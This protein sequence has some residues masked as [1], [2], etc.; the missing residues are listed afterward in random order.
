[1]GFSEKTP[2]QV[3]ENIQIE[4]ETMTSLV[5]G[6][7][8]QCGKLTTPSLANLRTDLT[9]YKNG[10]SRLKLKEIVGDV[11]QMHQDEENAGALFQAASQFNL[12]E[13]TSPHVVPEEGV[14]IYQY[15]RTQGPACAIAAG[16][17]TI[18]RNYFAEVNGKIG[19]T[20][21]NQID[22]LQDLGDILGNENNRLWT[23]ENGYA[24]PTKR[25]L[26]EIKKQLRSKDEAEKDILRQSLRI[27]IQQDTQI[28]LNDCSHTVTQAYCSALPVAYS[29]LPADLWTEFAQLIL[30]AS[31][32]ATFFSALKN[33]ERTGNKCVLLTLV[34]GGVFGNRSAWIFNAIERSLK[35]F[36][37]TP[38]EVAIVSYGQSQAHVLDFINGIDLGS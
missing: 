18:Y 28:T 6:K 17:G 37:D 4:G 8:Y 33:Y 27:G 7:S 38:L 31:Y 16:A 1:M 22:C 13:M 14:G 21:D 12:L 34:G 35:I 9:K 29:N 26:E 20:K 23:M 24:L 36:A 32:E 2:T 25:G 5:N 30:E 3:R 10:Q 11:Q 19:Q 15:D